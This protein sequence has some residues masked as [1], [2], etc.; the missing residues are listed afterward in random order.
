MQ[1]IFC[2]VKLL[3]PRQNWIRQSLRTAGVYPRSTKLKQVGVL[4]S[5]L[6]FWFLAQPEMKHGCP[7][8]WLLWLE[9][10][11]RKPV[12]RVYLWHL[13]CFNLV[14]RGC[15][16]MAMSEKTRRELVSSL[17]GASNSTSSNPTIPVVR[18]TKWDF[19]SHGLCFFI[20]KS[21]RNMWRCSEGGKRGTP[22]CN[23]YFCP[24]F[25][26]SSPCA[27]SFCM[28]SK[29]QCSVNFVKCCRSNSVAVLSSVRTD[30]STT[31]NASTDT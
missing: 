22:P 5:P 20:S 14:D 3:Y 6:S 9:T 23:L 28:A 11:F 19:L 4:L 16:N 29:P 17:R 13:H 31:L 21:E 7:T 30:W 27:T 15:K 24:V 1:V 18:R 25:S 10:C 2:F 12:R 8:K 26:P